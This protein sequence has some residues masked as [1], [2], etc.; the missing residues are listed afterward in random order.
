P[1][2]VVGS[3]ADLQHAPPPPEI[4]LV[5]SGVSG[6]GLDALGTRLQDVVSK[7][8]A[9]EPERNPVVVVRPGRDPYTV[10]REGVG[11]RVSGRR[12][13]VSIGHTTFEFIPD[14]EMEEGVPG[15][16]EA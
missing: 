2:L 5:V 7:A 11:F 3:K 10:R 16:D 13:E 9:D 6:E 8:I 12:V 1:H 15:G 4:D 14:E